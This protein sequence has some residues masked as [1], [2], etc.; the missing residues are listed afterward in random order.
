MLVYRPSR[1]NDTVT[2]T[3][4]GEWTGQSIGREVVIRDKFGPSNYFLWYYSDLSTDSNWFYKPVTNVDFSTGS[5]YYRALYIGPNERENL[6][7]YLGTV[8]SSVTTCSLSGATTDIQVSL[9]N[10]GL[11]TTLGSKDSIILDNEVDTTSKLISGGATFTP[12]I[13]VNQTLSVGQWMKIWVKVDVPKNLSLVDADGCYYINVGSLSI[14]VIQDISRLSMSR[15]FHGSLTNGDTV[16]KELIPRIDDID[17]IQKVINLA[18]NQTHVFYNSISGGEFH[19]LIIERHN[20]AYDNKFIDVNLSPV[21]GPISGINSFDISSLAALEN[22]FNCSITGNLD[23][24]YIVDIFSTQLPDRNY[25]YIFYNQ[26]HK[27]EDNLTVSTS[28]ATF[29]KYNANF[30]HD[31]YYWS[32]GVVYLNLNSFQAETFNEI[33]GG[34]DNRLFS[35]NWTGEDYTI[36]NDFF[37][38]SVSMQDDL[39]TTMGYNTE[40]SYQT[41]APSGFPMGFVGLDKNYF[42]ELTF[43]WE[44]DILLGTINPQIERTPEI[45]ITNTIAERSNNV[46]QLVIDNWNGINNFDL[47]HYRAIYNLTS[48]SGSSIRYCD[49]G[50]PHGNK[51]KHYNDA[52]ISFDTENNL[53]EWSSTFAFR[54]GV[55]ETSAST[56]YPYDSS[57][58]SQRHIIDTTEFIAVTGGE[59]VSKALMSVP[60]SVSGS[61]SLFTVNVKN[62]DYS[63]FEVLYDISGS[64]MFINTRD[65]SG[66]TLPSIST[67]ASL[68]LGQENVVTVNTYK[69]QVYD[70]GL[71]VGRSVVNYEIFLNGANLGRG[72]TYVVDS[73]DPLTLTYNPRKQFSGSLSYFELKPYLD[74]ASEYAR[75]MYA[76]HSNIAWARPLFDAPNTTTVA[77]DLQVFKNKRII[78]FNN[79]PLT[80]QE[81]IVPITLQGKGYAF[82]KNYSSYNNEVLRTSD[83]RIS[84]SITF[85]FKDINLNDIDVA[86]TLLG[87]TNLLDW[88]ADEYNVLNDRL[89]I[90]VKIPRYTGQRVVMYYNSQRISSRSALE[91]PNAFKNAYGVWTMNKFSKTYGYR[92]IDQKV[93]N[94][95]ENIMYLQRDNEKYMIQIDYQYMYG[96]KNVY[97]SNKF[98]VLFDDRAIGP[99]QMP[100][101]ESFINDNV[102]LFKPD[103]MTIRKVG[104]KYDYRLESDVYIPKELQ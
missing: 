91:H 65:A 26:L 6:Q 15:V 30:G 13:N 45:A 39:F 10:E 95:G 62:S 2:L 87:D 24:K 100:A 47:N 32:S 63:A 104:S 81:I 84:D 5:T 17:K 36:R 51:L 72:I 11:F 60:L 69:Q 27:Y 48:V 43:V 22:V 89:T 58:T 35:N 29:D 75:T 79:L 20:N 68:Y 33:S 97:K 8:S 96:Y 56:F 80:S 73:L 19:D 99:D 34:Y 59:F 21:T 94:A 66:N 55:I 74:N 46:A 64:S 98:D 85:D 82:A 14:Q 90:W 52:S 44:K 25:F 12:S 57:N 50:S 41:A 49:L 53:S 101:Y 9:W 7:E 67:S 77:K 103:F 83:Y 54:V 92:F 3:Y 86:F 93:F 28:S 88:T 42:S 1:G 78:Y 31:L 4:N 18:P 23:K 102:A 71:C 76:L 61:I 37:I 70:D 16:L 40:N 38:T